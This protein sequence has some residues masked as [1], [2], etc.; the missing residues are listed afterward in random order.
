MITIDILIKFQRSKCRGGIPRDSEKDLPEHP[1][2]AVG[3]ECRRVWCAAQAGV[4]GAPSG[5]AP[6]I[7]R[8]LRLLTS[9]RPPFPYPA[10]PAHP[11]YCYIS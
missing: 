11:Q 7:A 1:G 3:S 5:R 10:P 6:R 2:W 4:A 8:S 9:P